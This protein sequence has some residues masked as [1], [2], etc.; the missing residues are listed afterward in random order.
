LKIDLNLRRSHGNAVMKNNNMASTTD[1]I[2][3]IAEVQNRPRRGFAESKQSD[4]VVQLPKWPHFAWSVPNGFLRS[5][6]FGA[7]GKGRRRY[8][9]GEQIPALEGVEVRYKGERLDQG[10]LDIWG[11]VLQAVRI[12]ATGNQCRITTYALLKLVGRTDTGK[13]RITIKARIERLVANALTI[14]QGRYTY[15]GSLISGAAKDEMTQEWVIELDPKLRP[16][17]DVDQFTQ[18][19]WAIRQSLTGHQLAQWLQGFY[20]SHAK[21]YPVK[22]ETIHRLCGSESTV[23]SDFAKLLRKA[24]DSLSKAC[25][26]HGQPFTYEIINGLVLTWKTP[27]KPQRK[28]LAAKKRGLRRA[29]TWE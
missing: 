15:I 1:L 8:I 16:L 3:I 7:I 12:Q 11:G 5:A 2:S 26:V 29:S 21:P 22:I 27:S 20:A 24:L 17:F 13:N 18:I 10:D 6:L 23:M 25:R 14:K 4:S 9:N 19:D 28:H